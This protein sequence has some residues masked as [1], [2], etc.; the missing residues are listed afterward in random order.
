VTIWNLDGIL[1]AVEN[2]TST[3]G[4]RDRERVRTASTG[5]TSAVEMF[6]KITAVAR[7]PQRR[8]RQRE[9][10]EL[11]ADIEPMLALAA[12]DKV[13]VVTRVAD[14]IGAVPLEQALFE[15]GL[16]AL[17]QELRQTMPHGGKLAVEA[18]RGAP[19]EPELAGGTYVTVRLSASP[20]PPGPDDHDRFELP[21]SVAERL[22]DLA[23]DKTLRLA[24]VRNQARLT[25]GQVTVESPT[26]IAWH[27]KA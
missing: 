3:M 24:L 22:V 26:A 7:Q 25:G 15:A 20:T 12:G 14:D 13:E 11:L 21:P 5:A 4:E 10:A 23:S 18:D 9:L 6:K 8:A 27:L 1:R 2:G 19:S 16:L 17:A